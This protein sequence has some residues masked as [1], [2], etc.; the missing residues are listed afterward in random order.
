MN[1]FTY[2]A[3]TSMDEALAALRG[4]EGGTLIAGGQSLLPVMKL[5]L[6]APTDVVSLAGVP[7]LGGHRRRWRTR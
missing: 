4:A 1:D 7:G 6:A 3:P 2:H 5:N